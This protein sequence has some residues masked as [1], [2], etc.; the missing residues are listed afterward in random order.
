MIDQAIKIGSGLIGLRSAKNRREWEHEKNKEYLNI[1]KGNNLELMDKTKENELDMWNKTNYG[2]QIKHMKSAGLNVG[3]MYGLGGGAGATTG[4]GGVPS[5]GT[6]SAP[7]GDIA[8]QGIEA[9]TAAAS[10]KLMDAN[11]EK[12]KAE[13]QKIEGVDTE[14]S[15]AITLNLSQGIENA[16]AAEALTKAQTVMQDV[17]NEIAEAGK[18][19][20]VNKIFWSGKVALNA[21]QQSDNETYIS[22]ETYKDKVEQISKA[23][24][25]MTIEAEAKR[26]GIE[27]TREQIR[28]I[29]EQIR[30]SD[31][32]IDLEAFEAQTKAQDVGLWNAIG[33]EVKRAIHTVNDMTKDSGGY[34][35]Y[36]RKDK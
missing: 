36:K 32:K 33:G 3:M 26:A 15:K 12:A 27:L 1:Q 14:Q 30:I 4:A 8:G 21:L 5:S 6:A 7:S 23:T 29:G 25:L 13:A 18:E 11:A 17:Q 20:E 35:T 19:V 28:N 2:A 24:V 10:I 34:R 31:A 22:N 9:A 16:K